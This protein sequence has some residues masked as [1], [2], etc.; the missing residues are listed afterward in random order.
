[1]ILILIPL[2]IMS[3]V[4]ARNQLCAGAVPDMVKRKKLSTDKGLATT[5]SIYFQYIYKAHFQ[6][7]ET[8][9]VCWIH[10]NK[11]H[12]TIESDSE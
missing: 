7:K 12:S 10:R 5:V 9:Q 2:S 11:I 8:F 3:I 1:M 4:T 6:V